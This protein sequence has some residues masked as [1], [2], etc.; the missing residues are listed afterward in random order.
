MINEENHNEN[1]FL[2]KMNRLD[3]TTF[4]SKFWVYCKCHDTPE[5]ASKK[6]PSTIA[7]YIQVVV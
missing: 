1:E 5:I 7:A 2:K 3:V 4:S 6:L